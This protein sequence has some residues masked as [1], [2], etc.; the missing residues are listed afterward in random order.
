M[1]LLPCMTVSTTTS[2]LFMLPKS[3]KNIL[4]FKWE[5]RRVHTRGR[6]GKR[7]SWLSPSSFKRYFAFLLY[8]L[9]QFSVS[10]Y[11]RLIS[12]YLTDRYWREW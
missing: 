2:E 4:L 11:I 3:L 7:S 8:I 5:R 6:W 10:P 1:P 9:C 12:Y